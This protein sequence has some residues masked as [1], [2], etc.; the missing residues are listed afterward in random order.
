MRLRGLPA[1][2][3]DLEH[4][5]STGS[6]HRFRFGKNH[7]RLDRYQTP[8]VEYEENWGELVCLAYIQLWLARSLAVSL[9]RPWGCYLP[10]RKE[11][12]VPGSSEVQRD[13]GR[14]TCA[15][16]AEAFASLGHL[17]RHPNPVVI[18]ANA[19]RDNPQASAPGSR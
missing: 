2:L 19:P 18:Q 16:L 4:F 13:L 15:E 5:P 6:G 14:I 7:L 3:C 12:G 9:P 1:T 8:E 17:L 10:E 11:R